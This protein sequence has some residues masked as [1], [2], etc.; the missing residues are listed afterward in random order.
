MR[1]GMEGAPDGPV[2]QGAPK[3]WLRPCTKSR[4]RCEVFVG[5]K[6]LS[7]GH[8]KKAQKFMISLNKINPPHPQ[9]IRRKGC[10]VNQ[11]DN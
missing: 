5:R 11:V 1:R 10:G 7:T 3:S 4:Q 6:S 2:C 9:N 8:A